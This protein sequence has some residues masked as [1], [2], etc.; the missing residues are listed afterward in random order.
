MRIAIAN[1][2]NRLVGGVEH[3]ISATAETLL[4]RGHEVAFWRQ[5]HGPEDR[6]VIPATVRIPIWDSSE[7]GLDRSLA[8]LRRWQPD[9][10]YCQLILDPATEAK[11][12]EV[13]PSVFFAHDYHGTCIS[14]GKATHFP[15]LQPCKRRFGPACLGHF[16]LR[17]CGGKNPITMLQDYRLN[18]QRLRLLTQYNQV[19][20]HSVH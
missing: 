17:R 18:V 13:A 19:I 14:G 1:W 10:I 11:V 12:L 2:T 20:T 8:G 7:L 5:I 16:Y 6:D 4:D 15:V 9:V 3:Y